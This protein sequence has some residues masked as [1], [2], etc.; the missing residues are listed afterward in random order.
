VA[1]L[2]ALIFVQGQRVEGIGQKVDQ[3]GRDSRNRL[4]S[5][6]LAADELDHGT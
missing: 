5:E 3:G 1:R 6:I 4:F 2:S